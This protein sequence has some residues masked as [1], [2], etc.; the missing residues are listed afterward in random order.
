MNLENLSPDKQEIIRQCL[1]AAVE[2]PFFPEWEFHSLIGL[3]REEV[4]GILREWPR[5]S[6]PN[7]DVQLAV[8]NAMNNLLGYPHGEWEVWGEWISI[9]PEALEVFFDKLLRGGGASAE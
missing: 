1:R 6:A 8:N 9:S 2:G 3:E 7:S 5:P 4:R